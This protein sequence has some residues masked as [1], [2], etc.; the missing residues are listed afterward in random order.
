M[1]P[2]VDTPAITTVSTPS[3]C[4]VEAS[5]VPKNADA[6]CLT[7]TTSPGARRQRQG[8]PATGG[9]V[10]EARQRRHLAD[11]QAGVDLSAA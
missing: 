11:E 1:Q 7:T 5:D 9:T 2:D 8:S 3:V 10:G 4:S 6:Y